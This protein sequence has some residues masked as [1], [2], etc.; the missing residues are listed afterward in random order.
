MPVLT[1]LPVQASLLAPVSHLTGALSKAPSHFSWLLAWDSHSSG[2]NPVLALQ[3]HQP[4]WVNSS[5][6]LVWFTKVPLNNSYQ[7][8]M[9]Q[10]HTSVPMEL[11]SAEAW[12]G[13][14]NPCTP[15]GSCSFSGDLLLYFWLE[16]GCAEPNW[17]HSMAVLIF[18]P[19]G[20]SRQQL[21]CVAE[22]Q[23]LLFQPPR[24]F[25]YTVLR[26]TKKSHF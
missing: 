10:H 21:L 26:F 2:E 25:K 13:S 24:I 16:T 1:N 22:I 9:A 8:H 6:S 17:E 15:R 14:V 11:L 7:L 19:P 4:L 5:E 3:L 18:L 12:R 20:L 23:M